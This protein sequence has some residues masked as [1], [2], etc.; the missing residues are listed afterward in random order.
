MTICIQ[1][2]IFDVT[3]LTELI[4]CACRANYPVMMLLVAGEVVGR[5]R[6]SYSF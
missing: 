4:T 1:P 3:E 5:H 6:L 2:N